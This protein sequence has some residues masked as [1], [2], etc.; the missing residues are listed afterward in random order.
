MNEIKSLKLYSYSKL[1]IKVQKQDKD[2]VC[3][4]NVKTSVNNGI[5]HLDHFD[6][7]FLKTLILSNLFCAFKVE[8]WNETHWL[9]NRL[10][11]TYISSLFLKIFIATSWLFLVESRALTTFENTPWPVELNIEYW[12]LIISPIWISEIILKKRIIYNQWFK[13]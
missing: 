12:L 4:K 8:I 9:N 3:D 5:Y 11:K 1:T 6:L 13:N 2:V 7:V 10:P